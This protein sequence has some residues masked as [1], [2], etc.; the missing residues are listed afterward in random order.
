MHLK[1]GDL[2]EFPDSVTA[3]GTKH[4]GELARMVA[5]GARSVMLYVVQR[6]DCRAFSVAGDIDPAYAAA[7]ATAR[8]QGVELLCYT[9]RIRRTGIHLDSPLPI[10]I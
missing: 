1:R 4:L 2:A 8:A 6:A 7:L 5:A 10:A 3:R 9:C